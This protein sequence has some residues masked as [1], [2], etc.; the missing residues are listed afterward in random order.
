MSGVG[1]S[2]PSEST[3][4]VPV[5]FPFASTS[6]ELLP[7]AAAVPASAPA[8]ATVAAPTAP[9]LRSS[10][11]VRPCR[12][13]SRSPWPRSAP[14]SSSLA[15]SKGSYSP[16]WLICTSPFPPCPGGSRHRRGDGWRDTTDGC[17]CIQPVIRAVNDCFSWTC[18]GSLS[19]AG[20]VGDPDSGSQLPGVRSGQDEVDVGDAHGPEVLPPAGSDRRL[21]SVDP[22]LLESKPPLEVGAQLGRRV[23]LP[24][25]ALLCRHERQDTVRSEE[26]RVGKEC[27]SRGSTEHE[28]KK[29]RGA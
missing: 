3:R 4:S 18:G 24:H 17:P 22:P 9:R 10:P 14:A 23:E 25:A 13:P 29:R 20:W 6:L 2:T 1:N 7:A 8:P 19:L 15:Y 16:S 5:N 27:R 12:D 21:E 28:M 11:R 26:R